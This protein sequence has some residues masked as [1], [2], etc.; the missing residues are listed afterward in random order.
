MELIRVTEEN[1]QQEHICC[2]VSNNRDIQVVAKKAWMEERLKEGLVFLK[3]NVRGKCFM[4]YIPAEAAWMPIEADGYMY[5][6]CFWIAGQLKGNGYA[7]LLLEECIKES[8]EKGKKGLCI[9]ASAKKK[10]FLSE[11]AYLKHKGF[12]VADTAEPFFELLYLPFDENAEVPRFKNCVKTPQI[13]EMGYV[14]YYTHQCPFTAKYG[15][16]IERVAQEHGIPFK[17]ILIDTRE[18]TQNMPVA[19]TT[20]ALFRDGK[21]VTNEILSEKK[22]LKMCG[23]EE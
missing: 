20:Y 16:L 7:N 17:S 15:P 11:G 22:F 18:Q 14:L 3:G 8:K 21:F 13:D 2:A 1:L 6:D 5:I 9:R 12:R 4:E 19:S 10:P 23:V